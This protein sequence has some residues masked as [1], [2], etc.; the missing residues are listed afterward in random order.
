ML[1]EDEDDDG[2]TDV[3]PVDPFPVTSDDCPQVDLGNV[4]PVPP[5]L[6]EVERLP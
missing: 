6:P 2:F 3:T 1:L 4:I 5:V